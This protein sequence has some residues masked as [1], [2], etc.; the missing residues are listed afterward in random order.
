M[1]GGRLDLEDIQGDILRAYGNAYDCTSYVFVHV[2][3]VAGGRAWLD[4]V[5]EHV[6][7][8]APWTDGKPQTT[9]NVALTAAGLAALGVAPQIVGT[10]AFEFRHGMASRATLLGDV[11]LSA[12]S[13]WEPGLGTGAAHVLLV[14]NAQEFEALEHAL[15]KLRA[16]VRAAAG[17][18]IVGEQHAALL[19]AAREHFGF[20]DGF[21]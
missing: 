9:L 19:P 8:A 11:G 5:A 15:G 6:T 18:K 14:V 4:E 20:A 7:T 10:F 1:T 3:D 12:P 2:D 17:V 21:A 13:A 16:A